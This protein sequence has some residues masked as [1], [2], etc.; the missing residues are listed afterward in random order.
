MGS[1]ASLLTAE[2]EML[3]GHLDNEVSGELNYS[4]RT[5]ENGRILDIQPGGDAQGSQEEKV[6][7]LTVTQFE[8]DLGENSSGSLHLPLL[9]QMDISQVYICP[10]CDRVFRTEKDRIEHLLSGHGVEVKE[11]VITDIGVEEQGQNNIKE[12]ICSVCDKKFMKP[13]QLVRHMR[14]HTGERPFACLMCRK[15]FNQKNALQIHMKKHTGERPYVCP[16]CQY[17]FSQKGNLKTHIQRSHAEIAQ[18]LVQKSLQGQGQA[19]LLPEKTHISVATE[20]GGT[21]SIDL[22]DLLG[23]VLK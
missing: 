14:V 13:S 22:A 9:D 19:G 20:Q 7:N 16:F 8:N 18:Q 2:R 12:K 15:S 23:P 11:D 1:T 17:A 5:D 6:L 10:W 21:I 4:V 3:V